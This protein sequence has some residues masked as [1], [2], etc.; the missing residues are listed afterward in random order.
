MA[1]IQ[2]GYSP[3]TKEAAAVG[4]YQLKKR[5]DVAAAI[6]EVTDEVEAHF[7]ARIGTFVEEAVIAKDL[8]K[9]YL[10]TLSGTP[11]LDSNG[12]RVPV[13][14]G[15]NGL[16]AIREVLDR[17][18]G[19]PVQRVE[20]DVGERVDSLIR[21]LANKRKA[22]PQGAASANDSMGDGNA[23]LGI[24]GEVLEEDGGGGGG[25]G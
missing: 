1:Y 14:I 24:L 13:L 3:S 16:A 5:E 17:A 11:P 12:N 22:L 18:I 8:L 2:A 19:R 4:A 9:N 23:D 15:A 21:D 25:M 20:K 6:K 7:R 10:L